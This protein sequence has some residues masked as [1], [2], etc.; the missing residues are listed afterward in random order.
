MDR[1]RTG[2]GC[3]THQ[4]RSEHV[5]DMRPVQEGIRHQY[6]YGFPRGRSSV[7]RAP[8]WHAGGS[9]VRAPSPPPRTGTAIRVGRIDRRRRL[10]LRYGC[11]SSHTPGRLRTRALH[12]LHLDGRSRHCLAVESQG[13][14]GRWLASPEPVA[15]WSMVATGALFDW[16]AISPPSCDDPVHERVLARERQAPPV[17]MLARALRVIRAAASHP[18]RSRSVRMLRAWMRQACTRARPLSKSLLPCDRSLTGSPPSLA[19]SS[20][21]KERLLLPRNRRAFASPW[22]SELSIAG[23]ASSCGSFSGWATSQHRADA[24]LTTT[25]KS[26]TPSSPC[27]SSSR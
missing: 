9:W 19:A 2:R 15:E 16:I 22:A 25:T 12:L 3:H 18:N 8:A 6:P 24:S 5:F 20:P 4:G 27:A 26:R 10:F 11:D 23:C 13:S 17:R 14:P 21:P 1:G 7:G